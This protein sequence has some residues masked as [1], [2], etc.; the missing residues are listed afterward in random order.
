MPIFKE[1]KEHL[2][3]RQ[4]A[5]YYGLRVGRNGMVCCPFHDDKHPVTRQIEGG[6]N[7]GLFSQ[8]LPA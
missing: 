6:R 8:I 7:G 2:T 1:I 4:I 3:T 5:E